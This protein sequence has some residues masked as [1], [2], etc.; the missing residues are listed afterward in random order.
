MITSYI[1]LKETLLPKIVSKKNSS[2]VWPPSTFFTTNF[3]VVFLLVNC[4]WH[5]WDQWTDCTKTCGGGTRTRSRGTVPAQHGGKEC[6]GKST[7]TEACN[8]NPCPG[9]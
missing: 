6:E 8:T 3:L 5:A 9:D 4:Q 1:I 2:R 7:E